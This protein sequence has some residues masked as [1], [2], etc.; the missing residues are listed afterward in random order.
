MS[1][2]FLVAWE[3]LAP[4]ACQVDQVRTETF[5]FQLCLNVLFVSIEYNRIQLVFFFKFTQQKQH[6][7]FYK[8]VSGPGDV[9][10][11]HFI[12]MASKL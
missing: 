5:T 3:T 12:L 10:R 1:M 6:I 7:Q 9:K 2:E 4:A 11:L 8:L